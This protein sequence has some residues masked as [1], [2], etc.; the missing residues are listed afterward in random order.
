[1]AG[2]GRLRRRQGLCRQLKLNRGAL[3]Q[4]DQVTV[5][6]DSLVHSRS[7][8]VPADRSGK[9][10]MIAQQ[11]TA[12][13]KAAY[14]LRD[15]LL[16]YLTALSGRSGGRGRAAGMCR[17]APRLPDGRDGSRREEVRLGLLEPL[18]GYED[19]HGFVVERDQAGDGQKL[20]GWEVVGP[21]EIL[22]DRVAD[23]DQIGRAHV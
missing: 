23:A 17:S 2:C 5:A 4:T 3:P 16:A 8:Y 9:N 14:R 19:V 6:A 20:A 1:M 18:A 22:V 10:A 7:F 12:S 15:D 13:G 11:R 21:R